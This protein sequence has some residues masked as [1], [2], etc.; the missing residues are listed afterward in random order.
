MSRSFPAVKPT[1]REF[2]MGTYPTKTYRSLAG[3]TVKRSF[4]NKPYGYQLSLEFENINDTTLELLLDHYDGTAGGFERFTLPDAVFAGMDS[5]T[6]ARIQAPGGIKWEYG[7]PP[8]VESVYKG[9]SSVS[10]EL[11]GE[12]EV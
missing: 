8:Q 12:L 3:T 1:S 2:T 5:I 9:I 10:V 7:G 11:V 6:R 4:G